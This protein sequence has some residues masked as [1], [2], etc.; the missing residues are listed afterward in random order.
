[1]NDERKSAKKPLL[2]PGNIVGTGE[3]DL[4]YPRGFDVISNGK[5]RFRKPLICY[6]RLVITY[7][8][9]SLGS[10]ELELV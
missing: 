8:K 4:G 10:V 6:D 5:Q 7:E 3:L 9:N 2:T 1:M